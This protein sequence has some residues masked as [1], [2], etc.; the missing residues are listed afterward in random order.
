MCDL[1]ILVVLCV[2]IAKAAREKG[3]SAV[4]YVFLL[5]GLFLG[6]EISGLI[7]GVVIAIG[8]AGGREEPSRLIVAGFG[9]V[10]AVIGA[11]IAFSIVNHLSDLRDDYPLRERGLDFDDRNWRDQEQFRRFNEPDRRPRD[12]ANRD[13]SEPPRSADDRYQSE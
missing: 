4:G 6:G 3:R 11:V 13:P 1:I 12:D 2:K 8:M 9:L 7:L 10:G 5:L